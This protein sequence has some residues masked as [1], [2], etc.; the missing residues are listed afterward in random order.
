L[1]FTPFNRFML[2]RK[3]Y[4]LLYPKPFGPLKA[5][6]NKE[7]TSV[8]TLYSWLLERKLRKVLLLSGFPRYIEPNFNTMEFYFYGKIRA[9]DIVYP[10]KTRVH[11]R[12]RFFSGLI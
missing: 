4:R 1:S 11:E 3:L 9:K 7:L 12:S 10:F 6:V 5:K 2:R 8:I